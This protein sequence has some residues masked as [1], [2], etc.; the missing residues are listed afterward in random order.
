MKQWKEETY[1]EICKEA[2]K[3]GATFGDEASIRSD[4]HSGTTWA[5]KGETPIASASI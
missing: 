5:P 1:P 4:Y 2:K 3:V